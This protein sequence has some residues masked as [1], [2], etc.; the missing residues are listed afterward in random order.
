MNNKELGRLIKEARIEKKMTQSEVVGDFITRNMLSQIENGSATPSVRT[1]EYLARVLGLN[2]NFSELS[3][4]TDEIVNQNG[5]N[6]LLLKR[7][8]HYKNALK[9]DKC[10]E[11]LDELESEI[12]NSSPLYDEFCALMANGSYQCALE[13]SSQGQSKRAIKYAQKAIKYS[14]LG[15][16]ANKDLQAKSLL[17]AHSQSTINDN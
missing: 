10:P 17:L 4:Q 11:T 13:F 9:N 5:S 15:M 3:I 7:L 8:M 6:D 14:E 16:Y 12:E 2:L 1:L